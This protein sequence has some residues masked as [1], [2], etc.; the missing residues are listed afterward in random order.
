M[1]ALRGAFRKLSG[2]QTAKSVLDICSGYN[3]SVTQL[4]H[5]CD[6]IGLAQFQ[7]SGRSEQIHAGF[8][9]FRGIERIGRFHRQRHSIL[10][11]YKTNRQIFHLIF[12]R[13]PGTP[14]IRGTP[15]SANAVI[16]AAHYIFRFKTVTKPQCQINGMAANIYQ[17]PAALRPAPGSPPGGYCPAAQRIG[18]RV[19]DVLKDPLLNQAFC[20]Q[21]LIGIAILVGNMEH[22]PASDRRFPHF[23]CV[24][25]TRCHRLFAD[26]VLSVFQS[27]DSILRVR[28]V[29]RTQE[30]Q[31][32]IFSGNNLLGIL[33]DHSVLTAEHCFAEFGCFTGTAAKRLNVQVRILRSK[34]KVLFLRNRAT[35]DDGCIQHRIHRSD[36]PF[37][38]PVVT[39]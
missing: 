38:A 2:R 29:W 9:F 22:F 24:C 20:V 15:F 26:D 23:L 32:N 16:G 13:L 8:L 14:R 10:H 35:A 34:G 39:P 19:V 25:Q 6:A 1:F 37:T 11:P 4:L 21:R 5:N 30:D 18:F 31:V 33:T 3:H 28:I 12:C 17:W 36:Y 27:T 7:S